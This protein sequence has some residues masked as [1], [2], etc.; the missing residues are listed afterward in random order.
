MSRYSIAG[1]HAL[2]CGLA[3]VLAAATP[4][5]AHENDT[6]VRAPTSGNSVGQGAYVDGPRKSFSGGA[7]LLST[8][9][10]CA[11]VGNVDDPA[12]VRALIYQA[13]AD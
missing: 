4:A 6:L 10:D 12:K 9:M 5:L 2:V 11:T 8:A 3:F 7:G 13:I 1:S